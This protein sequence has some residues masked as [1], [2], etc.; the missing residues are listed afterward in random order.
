MVRVDEHKG[1]LHFCHHQACLL[2]QGSKR[3]SSPTR[4]GTTLHALGHNGPGGNGSG[5]E[6]SF[7]IPKASRPEQG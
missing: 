7:R 2:A 5:K 4:Q 6:V 1:C 3:M